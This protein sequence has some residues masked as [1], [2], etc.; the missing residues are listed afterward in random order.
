MIIG[1]CF[2]NFGDIVLKIDENG[3]DIV[4]KGS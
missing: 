4:L 1:Q 3:L 2:M